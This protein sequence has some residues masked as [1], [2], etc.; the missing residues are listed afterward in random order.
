MERRENETR[1]LLI[2]SASQGRRRKRTCGQKVHDI[3][4]KFYRPSRRDNSDTTWTW[5]RFSELITW[6]K[7]KLRLSPISLHR[8]MIAFVNTLIFAYCRTISQIQRLRA[9][10]HTKSV[11]FPRG[12]TRYTYACTAN[13]VYKAHHE[14]AS[15]L[16]R[17]FRLCLPVFTLTTSLY[18]LSVEWSHAV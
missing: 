11:C 10:W 13:D 2:R 14:H 17:L 15:Q 9:R 16:V 8:C 4:C 18:S 6:D 1:I 12:N 5:T 3:A 7:D